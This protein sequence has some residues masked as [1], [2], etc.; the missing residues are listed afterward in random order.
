MH[1]KMVVSRP[2]TV[3]G[4][5][6]DGL[7]DVVDHLAI[8]KTSVGNRLPLRLCPWTLVGSAKG[9]EVACMG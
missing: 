3:D 2:F 4:P 8:L 7:M 1:P 6:I 5:A 9:S